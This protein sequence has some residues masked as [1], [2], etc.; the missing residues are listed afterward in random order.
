MQAHK[1]SQLEAQKRGTKPKATKRRNRPFMIQSDLRHLNCTNISTVPRLKKSK[2][3]HISTD[4][5]SEPPVR[6]LKIRK[7]RKLRTLDEK[8][9]AGNEV[10]GS[11]L[12]LKIYVLL[13]EFGE[14][15]MLIKLGFVILV[16]ISYISM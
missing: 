10:K 2:L 15:D 9:S 14:I 5:S 4:Q 16:R 11:Q 6:I 12:T 3:M 1:L 13:Y 7:P 8:W